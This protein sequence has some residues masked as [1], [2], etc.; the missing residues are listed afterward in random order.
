[1]VRAGGPSSHLSGS[2]DKLA[3]MTFL[4]INLYTDEFQEVVSRIVSSTMVLMICCIWLLSAPLSIE[5]TL[6]P[7]VSVSRGPDARLGHITP[8]STG[9]SV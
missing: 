8:A 1:M 2:A 5:Y 6:G 7:L 4:Q 3:Q 9:V